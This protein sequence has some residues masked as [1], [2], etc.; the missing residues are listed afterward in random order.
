MMKK[1]IARAP[2]NRG[3]LALVAGLVIVLGGGFAFGIAKTG[4][5]QSNTL[6]TLPNV[7]GLTESD[8]RSLLSGYTVTIQHS[9]D[10]RIPKGRVASQVPLPTSMVKKNSGVILTLSDGP[11]D[12][13]VPTG[14]VGMSLIDAR[15]SLTAAGLVIAQTNAVPSDKPQ[16]TVLEVDP[17]E[18]SVIAAGS[19]V[20]LQ[21]ASGDIEV[22]VLVGVDEIQARTEL[23]QAGFLVNEIQAYDANQP[24]GVV[25]AQAPQAGST[26]TIGSSV[27]ITVN[28][29]P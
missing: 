18:G 13:T 10:G 19:G 7:V 16:G 23:V 25:L 15:A 3:R 22:P 2:I 28:T 17:A 29:A 8:A 26:H 20:T 5:T 14:L 24:V 12:A 11:G 21:I 27:T 1:K 9:H 4:S 6:S